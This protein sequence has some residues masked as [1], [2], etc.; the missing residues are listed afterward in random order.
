M[1]IAPYPL[2]WPD[3]F[4]RTA[5]REAG[6]FKTHLRAALKN[7]QD[8]L[9]LFGKDSGRDVS[10]VVITSNMALGGMMGDDPGVAVWF[11]WDGEQRCIA[12]DRYSKP[13][14]NLQAVHHVLEARRTELRHGTLALVRA[15]M[16]GF[17][18]SLP[19]PGAKPWWVILGV[20]SVAPLAVCEAAYRRLAAERHPDKPGG[21]DAM[22]AELNM[23]RD[24]ARKERA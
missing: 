14:S 6:Q 11:L 2:A 12:V 20:A 22:M 4:P 21:S 13:E 23:A 7:V 18:L 24:V 17:A 5:K 3:S 16:K 9:R 10:S 15:T 1:T 8:S 19:A